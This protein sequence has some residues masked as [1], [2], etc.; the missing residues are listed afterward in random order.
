MTSSL[1]LYVFALGGL[2]D[3]RI[4]Y[5]TGVFLF[6]RLTVWETGAPAGAG[7]NTC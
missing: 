1:H 3:V 5:G 2:G 4:T 7:T 6:I